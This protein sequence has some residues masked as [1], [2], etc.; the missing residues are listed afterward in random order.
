MM[1]LRKI[2]LMHHL[3]GQIEDKKC[4]ECCH[5][6]SGRYHD[7]ILHKCELY[8]LTH[9]EASDWRLKYTACGLFNKE[10][11]VRNVI[12]KV[13]PDR[14][15]IIHISTISGQKSLFE[16][17]QYRDELCP[18][19]AYRVTGDFPELNAYA[20]I[21][22]VV[23]EQ[24]DKFVLEALGSFIQGNLNV[25]ITKEELLAA[26]TIFKKLVFCKDCKK[27]HA[28]I[29]WCDEHSYFVDSEGMA[30]S[31]AESPNWKMF[32]PDYFC[33]DGERK[34]DD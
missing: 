8:G 23:R 15:P 16:M 11:D 34:N 5:L 7:T 1:A 32:P 6:Q 9:S 25:E 31:P 22:M 17:S 30:C 18:I 12:S 33:K 14:R 13:V 4:S 21:G 20:K 19:K 2:E 29:G 3:Y 28:E 24:E 10:T 26:V 27:Y